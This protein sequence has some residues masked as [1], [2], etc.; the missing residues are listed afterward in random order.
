LADLVRERRG[1]CLRVQRRLQEDARQD[2]QPSDVAATSV[3]RSP[4][5][6][7]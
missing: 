1:F 6:V 5:K 4:K 2:A 3:T 7:R